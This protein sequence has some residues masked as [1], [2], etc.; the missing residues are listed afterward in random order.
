[1]RWQFFVG[2]WTLMNPSMFGHANLEAI[3]TQFIA[4]IDQQAGP[5]GEEVGHAFNQQ[6][7]SFPGTSKPER[8]MLH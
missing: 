1:V 8:W 7:P 2:R 3:R 6:F 5:A 4:R